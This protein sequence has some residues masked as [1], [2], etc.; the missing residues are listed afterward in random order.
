MSRHALKVIM[1]EKHER[2]TWTVAGDGENIDSI[3]VAFHPDDEAEMMARLRVA[4]KEMGAT[5]LKT[6]R[7]Q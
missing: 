4:L 6:E 5:N 1:D 3:T 7:P 2:G